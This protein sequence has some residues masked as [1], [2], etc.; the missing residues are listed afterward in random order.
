VPTSR[1]FISYIGTH[2]DEDKHDHAQDEL[3][4]EARMALE[5]KAIELILRFEPD[6]VR[7]KTNNPGFDL[8]EPGVNDRPIRWVEV[9][10]MARSLYDRPVCMSKEQFDCAWVN[11]EAYWLYVVEYAGEEQS[12]RLIRVNDPAGKA[13]NFTFDHGWRSTAEQARQP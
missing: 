10:A 2:P 3:D 13:K 12:A 5:A 4:H 11:G 1:P 7:T 8:Y 6:L 9:K